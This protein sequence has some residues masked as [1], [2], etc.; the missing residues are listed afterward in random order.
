[1]VFAQV[2]LNEVM[3]SGS[4]RKIETWKLDHLKSRIKIPVAFIVA[5]NVLC[6]TQ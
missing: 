4:A 3:E 6:K 5:L 1:M 2:K